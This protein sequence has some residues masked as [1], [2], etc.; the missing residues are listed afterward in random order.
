MSDPFAGLR[1]HSAEAVATAL[2]YAGLVAVLEAAFRQGALAFPRTV[3]KVPDGLVALMP[4]WRAE[5]GVVKLATVF[6]DNPTRHGRPTVQALVVVFDGA[7]G[8]PLAVVDGTE[9]TLRRTAAASALAATYLARP[10]AERLLVIGTGELAPHLAMAHVAVRP[11]RHIRVWGR[12]SE[13]A[14][15][16]AARLAAEA[17]SIDVAV[18]PGLDQAVAEADVISCA[19]RAI[20]PVLQGRWIAPGTHI[21]LVGSFSPQAR[22]C[23]DDTVRGA[24]IFVDTHEGALAEAGDLLIPLARGVIGRGQIL[25]E[26]ADLCRGAVQG[27]TASGDVTVFKSVGA[28]IEDLAAAQMVMAHDFALASTQT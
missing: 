4:A 22:E 6:P 19:T 9:L 21:D 27:R 15:A 20:E 10:E 28:A 1:V 7:T 5:L 3:L 25:G 26:L 16:L 2:P 11:I 24:R 12:S 18:A 14:E 8:A 23:D 17:P 13:K